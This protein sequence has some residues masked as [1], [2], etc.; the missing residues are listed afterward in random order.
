MN[1]A[2]LAATAAGLVG[3]GGWGINAQT[4]P[5]Q[6]AQVVNNAPDYSQQA[7]IFSNGLIPAPMRGGLR[8][9]LALDDAHA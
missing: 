9:Q 2:F 7:G 5:V 1:I 3:L 8:N 6:T 4:S